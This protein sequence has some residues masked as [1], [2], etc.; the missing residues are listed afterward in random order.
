MVDIGRFK[1]P[2][3]RM[4]LNNA[5][6]FHD[7]SAATIEEVVDYFLSDWYNNSPDGRNYPIRLNERERKAL[8][9][10]LEIL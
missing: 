7:N 9:E 5:P 8:I 10:F 1:V 6:Y 2:Q 4:L 3:L